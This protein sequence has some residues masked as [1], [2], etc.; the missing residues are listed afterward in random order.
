MASRFRI[1]AVGD[2]RGYFRHLGFRRT[3]ARAGY[4][5]LN[6]VANADVF[7]CH[8]LNAGGENESYL[9]SGSL[10]A[11]FLEAEEV[12]EPS[13]LTGEENSKRSSIIIFTFGTRA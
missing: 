4:V 7:G 6:Q 5:A 2:T 8:F 3:L 10:D 13:S 1:P 12:I 11:R 9:D